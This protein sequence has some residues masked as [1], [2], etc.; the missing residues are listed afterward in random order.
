VTLV[1]ECAIDSKKAPLKAW[2]EYVS[3]GMAK[4]HKETTLI[5]SHQ[6]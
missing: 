6:R 4:E 2:G 1:R 3:M 5:K